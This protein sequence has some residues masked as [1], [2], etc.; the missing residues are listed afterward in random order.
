MASLDKLVSRGHSVGTI[1]RGALAKNISEWMNEGG[2][3]APVIKRMMDQFCAHPEFVRSSSVPA[4]RVFL[5]KRDDLYR[6]AQEREEEVQAQKHKQDPDWW[7]DS[8][9]T[10]DN[11]DPR[12]DPAWWLG[13]D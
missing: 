8:G 12:H 4:W 11:D 3:S 5:Y 1:N 10:V 6:R 9:A 7:T 2:L 13:T